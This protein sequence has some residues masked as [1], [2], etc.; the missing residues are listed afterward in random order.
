MDLSF[1]FRP[2]DGLAHCLHPFQTWP[3]GINPFGLRPND[4][5]SVDP[6]TEGSASLACGTQH[7][8]GWL[9]SQVENRFG[10]SLR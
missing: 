7:P 9:P 3:V 4:L 6:G 5:G 8:D 1:S 2:V 10:T